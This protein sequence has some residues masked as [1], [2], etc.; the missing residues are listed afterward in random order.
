MADEF[1]PRTLTIIKPC[2]YK[3][4]PQAPGTTLKFTDPS[5]VDDMHSLM[6]SNRAVETVTDEHKDAIAAYQKQHGKAAKPDP[7]EKK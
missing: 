3:G 4:K 7:A 5:Q 1:K 2:L 6:A